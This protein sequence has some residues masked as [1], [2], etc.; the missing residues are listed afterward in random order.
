MVLPSDYHHP[1]FICI[2]LASL[3][4]A[5]SQLPHTHPNWELPACTIILSIKIHTYNKY[6]TDI[7]R[8]KPHGLWFTVGNDGETFQKPFPIGSFSVIREKLKR[9]I[10]LNNMNFSKV[11][12]YKGNDIIL[13]HSKWIFLSLLKCMST[14]P[15]GHL[16]NTADI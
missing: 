12:K 2:I 15:V 1:R 5:Q 6:S 7:S 11:L 8:I 10:N 14:L 16:T 4:C 3:W 13:Q 9:I